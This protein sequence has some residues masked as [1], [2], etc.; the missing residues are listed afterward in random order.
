VESAII[1]VGFIRY[2]AMK[3]LHT[4][5]SCNTFTEFLLIPKQRKNSPRPSTSESK[6]EDKDDKLN[7]SVP[8][9]KDFK[10]CPLCGKAN[11]PDH[12]GD[13]LHCSQNNDLQLA[14]SEAFS[15]IMEV[16]NF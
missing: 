16:A 5:L 4:I 9:E 14:L 11:P 6:D 12:E 10:I 2:G 13:C 8:E 3:S 15:H 1:K 7:Q